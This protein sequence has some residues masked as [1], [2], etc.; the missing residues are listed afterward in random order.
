MILSAARLK[1]AP[2]TTSRISLSVQHCHEVSCRISPVALAMNMRTV[3]GKQSGPQ[4][5]QVWAMGNDAMT[6]AGTGQN[7]FQ[8][9][10]MAFKCHCTVT[11]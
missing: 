5:L 11:V 7:G 9:V 4:D 1:T 6:I 10:I 2:L 3:R 8:D